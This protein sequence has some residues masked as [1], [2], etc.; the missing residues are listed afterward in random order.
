MEW[1][2]LLID[3]FIYK[4][5]RQQVVSLR[6]LTSDPLSVR[7]GVPQGSGSG[8]NSSCAPVRS[9]LPCP[10]SEALG[11]PDLAVCT[12]VTS[13]T[14]QRP[15]LHSSPHCCCCP[16]LPVQIELKYLTCSTYH[17]S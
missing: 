16:L 5:G 6:E 13:N 10:C 4:I 15:S 7:C 8:R 17:P 12:L 9:S 14:R 1:G 3:D 11:C 2:E